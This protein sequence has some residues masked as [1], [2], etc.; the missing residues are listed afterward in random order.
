MPKLEIGHRVRLGEI[1]G[2]TGNTGIGRNGRQSMRRRPAIHFGVFYSTSDKYA[3]IRDR[4]IPIDGHWME[5][6][7][8]GRPILTPYWRRTSH[9]AA[10]V[11]DVRIC[12]VNNV[13]QPYME[14]IVA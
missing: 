6:V 11:H 7:D 8:R 2:P 14:A 3:I 13:M 1:L 10:L 5:P 12:R 9:I 4:V